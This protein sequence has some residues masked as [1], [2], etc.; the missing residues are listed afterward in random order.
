VSNRKTY[1][2]RLKQAIEEDF[3]VQPR[4]WV[5]LTYRNAKKRSK[6]GLTAVEQARR[7]LLGWAFIVSQKQ[8]VHILPF[9]GVEDQDRVHIHATISADKELPL[10]VVDYWTSKHGKAVVQPYD[11]DKYGVIYTYGNHTAMNFA[12]I[13][14][15]LKSSCKRKKCKY[16]IHGIEKKNHERR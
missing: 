6:S 9:A 2:E 16:H 7:D 13:C 10:S 14:P 8:K 12:V 4:L 5:T 3:I 15:R 1:P 11:K